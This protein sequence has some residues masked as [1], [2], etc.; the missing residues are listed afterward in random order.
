[1]A[2]NAPIVLSDGTN[3]HTMSPAG[4]SGEGN[5]ALYQNLAEDSVEAR[6]TLQFARKSGK[7][8]REVSVTLRDPFA[9]VETVNGVDRTV[10]ENFGSGSCRLL[11]PV[12]WTPAQTLVLRKLLAAALL[13]APVAKCA[14][15]DE[16]VW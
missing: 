5:R 1:M 7:V 13:S 14:D 16:F 8:V 11:I 10:V 4:I 3:D 15:D 9:V 2:D 6:E 12:S